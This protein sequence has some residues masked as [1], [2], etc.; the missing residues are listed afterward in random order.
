[1]WGEGR[2][3]PGG[4]PGWPGRTG[5][6][7]VGWYGPVGRYVGTIRKGLEKI[8]GRVG[9]KLGWEWRNVAKRWRQEN[10]WC[11][12]CFN[13]LAFLQ[14]SFLSGYFCVNLASPIA[15]SFNRQQLEQKSTCNESRAGKKF[16][17]LPE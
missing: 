12:A 2:T 1:M 10:Q 8:Y 4:G 6:G 16:R 13:G 11:L 3:G 9:E 17:R 14:S 15:F 5:G 7:R